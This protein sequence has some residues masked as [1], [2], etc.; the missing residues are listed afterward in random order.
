MKLLTSLA[1]GIIAL[2][3]STAS[4]ADIKTP[5]SV[6]FQL[7]GGSMEYKGEEGE[8][9]G[10]SY[11]YYNY[12]FAP[13]YSVEV[14]LLGGTDADWDC[15]KTSGEWKCYSD[16]DKHDIFELDADDLEL[17]ALVVALK[18]DLA[19]S[20]RNKLYAKAGLS[21][22]NYELELDSQRIA[23]EDGVGFMLEGGWEYRWDMGIGMNV[24]LQY[25]KMGDLKSNTLNIGMSYAF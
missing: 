12:Q 24:G 20:K 7:G 2:T 5:H 1:T 25:Q 10:S 4:F 14:G 17:N 11:L 15:K 9:F 3:I 13:F 21:Y 23:D 18:T 16:D 8:G 19:L 22:Y 6:G